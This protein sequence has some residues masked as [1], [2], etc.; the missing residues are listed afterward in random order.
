M[1]VAH[2]KADM[3]TAASLSLG[4]RLSLSRKPA[5]P[6]KTSA[7]S[8]GQQ[9]AATVS[10]WDLCLCSCLL[11]LMSLWQEKDACLSHVDGRPYAQIAGLKAWTC[12]RLLVGFFS[13]FFRWESASGRGAAMRLVWRNV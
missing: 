6:G 8:L 10:R 5:A 9:M 12:M 11:V 3:R 1:D 7:A 13:K 2:C 4:P